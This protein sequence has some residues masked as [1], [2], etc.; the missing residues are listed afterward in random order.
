MSKNACLHQS[1]YFQLKVIPLKVLAGLLSVSFLA[2]CGG[3]DTS[4]T[5]ATATA[6]ESEAQKPR[7]ILISIDAGSEYRLRNS[8]QEESIPA[9]YEVFNHGACSDYVQPSFPSVTAAGHAALWTGAYGNISNITANSVHP[10]PRNEFTALAAISGY[11]SDNSSAEPIW[12]SAGLQ[13]LRAGGHHVTQ[14]PQT[15]GFP[16]AVGERTAE[17]EAARNRV[18]E[19]YQQDHVVVMNG[20]NK[21]VQADGLLTGENVQWDNQPEWQNISQLNS[22]LEPQFFSFT[23]NVGTFYGAIYGNERYEHIAINTQPDTEGAV[24]AT[25]SPVEQASPVNRELARHF[26]APLRVAHEDGSL[27]TRLRLFEMSENGREFMLFHTPMHIAETNHRAAQSA[28][29]EYVQGWFGNSATRMYSRGGF[30]PTFYQGGDGTAEARYL[31]TAEL[32]TKLFN[33]G[34]SWMWNEQNVELLVDYFPLG[35]SIDHNVYGY[36]DTNYPQYDAELAEKANALRN[37]AW[38]LVDLRLRHLMSLAEQDN[39]AVFVV[40][41]HGMR[42]SWLEFRPNVLMQ[43]AGLQFLDDNGMIDL[44]RSKAVS[45]NGSWITV[46]TDEWRG[47]IVP[48]EEKAAV[49]AEIVAALEALTDADGNRVIESIYVAAEHPELGLGGPA[50]GDVYWNVADGYEV[51]RRHNTAEVTGPTRLWAGHTHSATDP[52]MGTL[53]CAWGG[54]FEAGRIPMSRQIDVAPTVSEY[55]GIA[56]PAHAV[57]RSLLQDFRAV[58]P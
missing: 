40:G 44:N 47:G 5:T 17:N 23:N 14:A 29:E 35:D 6:S 53:T 24:I 1:K 20:Y 39:A 43:Q 37:N 9:F 54:G 11:S 26:S 2:A 34:S 19:G 10:L 33:K 41:D 48:Q 25:A 16:S 50:G 45:N 30:G 21:M 18:I 58:R 56:P 13:G 15:P 55:L 52:N 4:N 38:Q 27:F 51:N 32:A 7:A 31:E 8:L 42:A 57:G 49:I 36:L 12:I 22:T 46:N 3:A 28:Y